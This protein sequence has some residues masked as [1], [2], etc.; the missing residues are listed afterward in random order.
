MTFL[1]DDHDQLTFV[2]N[3][4]AAKLSRQQDRIVRI[5]N[6]RTRLHEEDRVFRDVIL[7]LGRVP[8]IVQ[9]DTQNVRRSRR[10]Q[11]LADGRRRSCVAELAEDVAFD[12]RGRAIR[13]LTAEL[14]IA[15]FVQKSD[16][17]HSVYLVS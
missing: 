13:V 17:L 4:V 5:L 15:D 1:A 12:Q 10:S 9:A 14:N 16:E 8:T 11:Q 6:R 7:A 3:G 2:V